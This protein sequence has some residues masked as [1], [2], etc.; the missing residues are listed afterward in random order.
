M[1]IDIDGL[2]RALKFLEKFPK[3]SERAQIRAINRGIRSAR[4][5]GAREVARDLGLRV[6]DARDRLELTTARPGRPEGRIAASRKRIPLIRFKG[7]SGPEPSRGKG[8]GVRSGLKGGTKR[9]VDAFIAT[10]RS[11]H[12]GVYRRR[13]RGRLPIVE[14]KGPSIFEVATKKIPAMAERAR[15]ATS[16]ELLR[17]L[18]REFGS[19]KVG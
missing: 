2:D 12:R 1:R 8:K 4:T 15:E 19:R 5:V 3:Q 16:K 17:L 13:G 11:G 18:R 6:G 7:T 10:M 14:L 9:I